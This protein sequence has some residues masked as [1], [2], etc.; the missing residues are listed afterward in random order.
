MKIYREGLDG[1]SF[2][3]GVVVGFILCVLL[4]VCAA[5][6]EYQVHNTGPNINSH[7]GTK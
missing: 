4:A 6:E 1:A 5:G 7:G 2:V 3:L